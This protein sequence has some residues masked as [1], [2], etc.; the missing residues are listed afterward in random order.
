MIENIN[1]SSQKQ[2]EGLKESYENNL[3]Q[4]IKLNMY[5][6]TIFRQKSKYYQDNK[7]QEFQYKT[8]QIIK[9]VNELLNDRIILLKQE[10]TKTIEEL[11]KNES[12][13]KNE[14]AELS[15]NDKRTFYAKSLELADE[16]GYKGTVN[17]N[18]NPW[19]ILRKN[20]YEFIIKYHPFP[21]KTGINGTS[22]IELLQVKRQFQDNIPQT[23]C[24]FYKE[25]IKANEE[26][27][28]QKEIDR[29]IT[30]FG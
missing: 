30:A 1:L 18:E 27:E 23:V 21:I 22:R 10:G 9:V 28:T 5:Y 12:F 13:L 17:L 8:S 25:W 4:T 7:E 26:P 29:I 24:S 20:G 3:K 2:K 6:N 11:F 16:L 15:D 14:K 19:L